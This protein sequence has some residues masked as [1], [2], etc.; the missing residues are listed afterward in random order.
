MAT[1]TFVMPLLPGKEATD[2]A[3]FEQLKTGPVKAR[4]IS[5]RGGDKA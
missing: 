2:L 5:P 3:M 1:L 4:P